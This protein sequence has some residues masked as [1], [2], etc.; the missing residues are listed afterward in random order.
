MLRRRIASARPRLARVPVG[1]VRATAARIIGKP[2]TQPSGAKPV[3]YRVISRKVSTVTIQT[4]R[5]ADGT[6]PINNDLSLGIITA[7]RGS[8]RL[9]G[10]IESIRRAGFTATIMLEVD[11][12]SC[13]I[14][15]DRAIEYGVAIRQTPVNSCVRNWKNLAERMLRTTQ[16]SWLLLMQDD[17]VWCDSGCR[18][19]EATIAHYNKI[20]SHNLGMLS[21]YTSPA[22]VPAGLDNNQGWVDARFY[23]KTIGLWGALALCFPRSS[24]EFLM[25]H[26]RF[27]NHN[28]S[29]ALDYAIGNTFRGYTEPPMSV[30]VHT[31]SLVDHTGDI[32]TIF[33][34]KKLTGNVASLRRGYN[35]R[36]EL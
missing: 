36:Q 25:T 35:Y 28:S 3:S 4:D 19:L 13:P 10:T 21:A 16:A 12:T 30:M 29:R 14:T 32:S 26:N 15:P 7:Q 2:Y 33:D 22:M 18:I 6:E 23:G 8:D 5:L 31:P 1:T 34:P 24:L 11:G 20:G 17:I 9:I 27:V